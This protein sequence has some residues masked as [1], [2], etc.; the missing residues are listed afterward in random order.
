MIKVSLGLKLYPASP[1]PHL[2]HK[3]KE[4][5]HIRYFK[6][7]GYKLTQPE[8]NDFKS[9][10]DDLNVDDDEDRLSYGAHTN[11]WEE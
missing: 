3:L 9:D 8:F 10:E 5:D 2:A 7:N 1:S 11:M 4:V 6:S